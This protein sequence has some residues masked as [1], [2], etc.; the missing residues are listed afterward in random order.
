MLVRDYSSPNVG[1]GQCF[2]LVCTLPLTRSSATFG[3]SFPSFCCGLGRGRQGGG[4]CACLRQVSCRELLLVQSAESQG[5]CLILHHSSVLSLPAGELCFL[6]KC[7]KRRSAGSLV[8]VS[9]WLVAAPS[10][11]LRSY[12]RAVLFSLVCAVSLSL[13]CCRQH[14]R[15]RFVSHLQAN[16]ICKC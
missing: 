2:T 3:P 11:G 8:G 15:E 10:A 12:P 4:G 5:L 7:L 6:H 9:R 16:S 1:R 14:G 13:L